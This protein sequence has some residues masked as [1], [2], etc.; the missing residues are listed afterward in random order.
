MVLNCFVWVDIHRYLL[1]ININPLTM[2]ESIIKN[3]E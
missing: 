1:L 3:Y 2:T